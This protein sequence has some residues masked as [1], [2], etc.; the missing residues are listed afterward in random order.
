MDALKERLRPHLDENVASLWLEKW[1]QIHAGGHPTAFF[2][3]YRLLR[4]RKDLARSNP[5]H[6]T[7]ARP[8]AV[9]RCAIGGLVYVV[10]PLKMCHWADASGL[11]GR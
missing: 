7:S 6:A 2:T 1:L 9:P 5:R 8:G 10:V 11:V 3:L 4:T